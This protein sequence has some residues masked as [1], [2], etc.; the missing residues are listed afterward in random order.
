MEQQTIGYLLTLADEQFLISQYSNQ[1]H[2]QHSGFHLPPPQL[3]GRH[4]LCNEQRRVSNL[5]LQQYVAAA[6]R[7]LGQMVRKSIEAR[8]WLSDTEPRAVRTV[9]KRIVEEITV[10]DQQVGQ[11]FEEGQR[12]EDSESSRRGFGG[13]T[14]GQSASIRGSQLPWPRSTFLHSSP[15]KAGHSISVAGSANALDT[16]NLITRLFTDKIVVFG[17][18]EATQVSIMT[19]IVKIVLKAL[20]EFVRLKTF[21]KFGFQQIQ[22]DCFYLH[23]YLTRFVNDEKIVQHMLDDVLNSVTLRCLH[24]VAM[25]WPVVA[26]ICEPA[27]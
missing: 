18:V 20:L 26:R 17:P 22:V 12:K 10:S 13:G 19:G 5:L 4:G 2:Q 11:L 21:S 7:N 8:D 9:M 24:P 1:N 16:S 3:T 27:S 15:N 6:G 14:F 25:D 23:Q